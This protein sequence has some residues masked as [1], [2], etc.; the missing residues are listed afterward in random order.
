MEA[1]SVFETALTD[2][3]M[4]HETF[5]TTV[6]KRSHQCVGDSTEH[7]SLLTKKQAV[8]A[9]DTD[10]ITEASDNNNSTLESASLYQTAS[11]Q[12]TDSSSIYETAIGGRGDVPTVSGGNSS[13]E[14]TG[15]KET[16][17]EENS[18]AL[19]TS[20]TITRIRKLKL[21]LANPGARAIH[22]YQQTITQPR[23]MV[24]VCLMVA[25]K[26]IPGLSLQALED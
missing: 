9:L 13:T 16:P 20:Q 22:L 11:S 21:Y 7:E 24:M 2:G 19:S 1:G 6:T 18:F 12:F 17:R 15:C 23:K 26:K 10:L 25:S 8:E 3:D 14:S 5:S 4:A